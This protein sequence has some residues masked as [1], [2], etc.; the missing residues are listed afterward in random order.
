MPEIV[1]PSAA[2]NLSSIA[3]PSLTVFVPSALAPRKRNHSCPKRDVRVAKRIANEA[4]SLVMVGL[5]FYVRDG[6][7]FRLQAPGDA[8]GGIR[9]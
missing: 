9:E 5:K 6:R 7:E 3:P 2:R 1:V 8:L 4:M